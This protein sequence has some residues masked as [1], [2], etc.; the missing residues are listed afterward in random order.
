MST[1][2]TP[3]DSIWLLWLDVL[4]ARVLVWIA[5]VGRRTELTPQAHIY[6]FDR[7]KRLAEWHGAR[8]HHRRARR[9]RA[10]ADEHYVPGA[11]GGGPPY[12]AAMAMPRPHQFIRTDAVS[13]TTLDGP[14]DAA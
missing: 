8:G 10:K 6:F 4:S 5:T 13:R 3:P 7:Y 9:L 2:K 14:D 1:S 11:D 12:A